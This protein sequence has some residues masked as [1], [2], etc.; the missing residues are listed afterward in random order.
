MNIHPHLHPLALL[1][2][3]LFF[4]TPITTQ[5]DASQNKDGACLRCHGM[6]TL[7]YLDPATGGLRNL[8]IDSKAMARSDHKNLGCR[9][10]HAA[11]FEVYP[12][13]EEARRERLECLNCHQKNTNFP[14]ALFESI[15]RSFTRSI[16]YQSMQDTFTCFSCHNP[17]DFRMLSGQT[18]A[19]L[20]SVVA[21]DNGACRHCHDSPEGIVG[22]TGRLFS[23]L[24]QTHAWLPETER[25]WSKV[26]CVECHTGGDNARGGHFILGRN[27]AVR[28]CESCHSQNSILATKLYRHRTR[29]ERRSAGFLHSVVMNDAYVIGMTRNQWLDWGGIGLIVLTLA[30][31]GA[32]GLA[33]YLVARRTRHENHH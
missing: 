11:G 9:D 29:E 31:V 18:R 28:A 13:F 8:S 5:A 22:R 27:H 16:H 1:L 24:S 21:R 25:H 12:H 26:R 7:S 10:C 19:S 2:G 30:G 23:S 3:L 32:H 6:P 14:R 4:V 33:R 20:H 17:H 15:E